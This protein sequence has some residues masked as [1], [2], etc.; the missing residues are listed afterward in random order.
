[1][2]NNYL[3]NLQ[4][5]KKFFWRTFW[6]LMFSFG[7][8]GQRERSQGTAATH[9]AIEAAPYI[10]PNDIEKQYAMI[11]SYATYYN[12]H[13]APGAFIMALCLGM[14]IEKAKGVPITYDMIQNIKTSLAGPFAALGDTVFQTL[15]MPLLLS[16]GISLSSEGSILGVIFCIV[17]YIAYNFPITYWFYKTGLRGGIEGADKLIN[18]PLKDTLMECIRIL[19]ITVI[20]AVVGT[21]C[22]VQTK[23]AYV[24]GDMTVSLQSIF[25]AIFPGFLTV[26]CAFGVLYLLK[27]K[28]WSSTK[29]MLLLFVIA[30]VGYF[31]KIL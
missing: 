24:N 2:D 20:G 16:I 13:Q 5:D 21:N 25:D 10:Y 27:V 22:N 6:R 19:G 30:V 9:L 7:N 29:V 3:D 1:M 17:V 28:R 11:Q 4:N 26:L 23:L 8:P 15:L 18:S 12:S 31:T 14:E